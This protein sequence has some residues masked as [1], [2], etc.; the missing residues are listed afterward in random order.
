M[1]GLIYSL[2]GVIAD[3]P[4]PHAARI[5][6]AKFG[7]ML[8]LECLIYENLFANWIDRIVGGAEQYQSMMATELRN[9]GH[10]VALLAERLDHSDRTAILQAEGDDVVF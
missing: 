9:N 10:Q 5:H 2:R 6:A 1:L 3:L 8:P 4:W 7:S